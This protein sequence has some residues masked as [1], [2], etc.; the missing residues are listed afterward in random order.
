MSWGRL[1]LQEFNQDYNYAFGLGSIPVC[2]MYAMFR[3]AN[4]EAILGDENVPLQ[5]EGGF[6]AAGT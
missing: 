2:D 4:T 5:L 1:V 3:E 6:M